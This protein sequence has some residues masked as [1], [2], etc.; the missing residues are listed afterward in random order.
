GR[1]GP[2]SAHDRRSACCR[3]AAANRRWPGRWRAPTRAVGPSGAPLPASCHYRAAR[4]GAPRRPGGGST[5]A[6]EISH[7]IPAPLAVLEPD[8]RQDARL[9]VLAKLRRGVQGGAIQPR[10]V[11]AA[12]IPAVAV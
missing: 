2:P 11:G 3:T 5:S 6:V 9:E 4:R 1:G 10:L 12:V 7:R 8:L